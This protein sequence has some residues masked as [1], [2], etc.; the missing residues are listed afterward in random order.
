LALAG[1]E[2]DFS[3]LALERIQAVVYKTL[4]ECGYSPNSDLVK[5]RADQAAEKFFS[6]FADDCFTS[7]EREEKKKEFRTAL[8]EV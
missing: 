4:A 2:L 1:Y 5:A 7:A 3:R 6:Y 8:S